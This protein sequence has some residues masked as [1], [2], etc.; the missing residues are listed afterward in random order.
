MTHRHGEPEPGDPVR[1]PGAQ[2]ERTWF[3]WRRTTLAFAVA[4]ALAARSA[5]R[6]GTTV[7]VLAA[8]LG[9]LAWLAMLMTAHR[10]IGALSSARP[11]AM[12]ARELGGVLLPVL[13]LIVVG[14]MTL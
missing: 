3:A 11:A 8:C 10:R 6:D 4:A 13:V 12:G 14:V 7:A 2:P 1:D 5:L 9:A